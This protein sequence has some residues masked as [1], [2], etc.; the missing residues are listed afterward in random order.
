[1]Y[2]SSSL[3][4][5][6]VANRPYL[7]SLSATSSPTAQRY[8]G[9]ANPPNLHLSAKYAGVSDF[10]SSEI[11]P[12]RSSYR[13]RGRSLTRSG[14]G[15]PMNVPAANRNPYA[16]MDRYSSSFGNQ[17]T[18]FST[19]IEDPYYYA[20]GSRSAFDKPSLIRQHRSLDH[21]FQILSDPNAHNV[22][23]FPSAPNADFHTANSQG[24]P[25]FTS[26]ATVMS[27]A[28]YYQRSS[29][30]EYGGA[31]NPYDIPVTMSQSQSMNASAAAFGDLAASAVIPP[32]YAPV[33][34]AYTMS[35]PVLQREYETLKREYEGA[36]QKLYTTMNSIKTFWSPELKKERTI[37]REETQRLALLNEQL[38][39]S[40]QENQVNH[41]C[42]P[43]F[44]LMFC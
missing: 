20:N 42:D 33:K 1:M 36:V 15:S 8:T 12:A 16:T 11:P 41:F 43:I 17:R 34:D 29:T 13:E 27:T 25:G 28:P 19:S 18:A 2:D 37:R 23:S 9:A 39:I 44:K 32:S 7:Q 38:R 31:T 10:Y 30:D 40:A 35:M 3:P 5:S 26:A 21:G 24:Y 4:R 6:A 22:G 14:R